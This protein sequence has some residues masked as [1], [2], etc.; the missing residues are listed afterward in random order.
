MAEAETQALFEEG[1][2]G[3][4]AE[5]RS[6]ETVLRWPERGGGN[7]DA[8]GLWDWE[9]FVSFCHYPNEYWVHPRRV[10]TTP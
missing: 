5:L 3:C 2:D 4:V 7:P 1:R 10:G 6:L 9:D 8:S